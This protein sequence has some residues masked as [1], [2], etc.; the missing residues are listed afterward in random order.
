MT[1]VSGTMYY[2]DNTY[3]YHNN[4]ALYWHV[5]YVFIKHLHS[6][7]WN[8]YTWYWCGYKN[9][10]FTQAN[11]I[12]KT[13]LGQFQTNVFHALALTSWH[14]RQSNW[15]LQTTLSQTRISLPPP[16]PPAAIL[17]RPNIYQNMIMF[18]RILLSCF[19]C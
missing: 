7:N 19:N 14:T 1:F 5:L 4:C 13:S 9:F 18:V 6:S 17:V 3:Q 2:V 12:C 8:V 16:S 15:T 10:S 11:I